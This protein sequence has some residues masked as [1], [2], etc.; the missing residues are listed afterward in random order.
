[1]ATIN[2]YGQLS[3][4]E[5]AKRSANGTLLA[6][7]ENLAL[8]NPILQDAPWVEANGVTNHIG[9]RRVALPTGTW[10]KINEGIN[11]TA[12]QTNQVTEGIGLLEDYSDVDKY[13]VD[14]SGN[15]RRFRTEEDVAHVEGLSQQFAGGLFYGSLSNDPA[16]F[17]GLSVRYNLTSLSNVIG[18]SGTGSDTCSIWIVQWGAR[19]VHLLYPKGSKTYGIE[20][21]DLGEQTKV[22]TTG[23]QFQIY[24]T[25]FKLNAGM[26]IHDDRC[27]Q[28]I[29]NIEASGS[30]NIFDEDDLITALNNLPSNG[31]G[32][33]IYVSKA[34]KNQMDINAKDK[35]NVAYTSS[36]VYGKPTTHFWGVP[37]KKCDSLLATETAIS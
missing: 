36:E 3:L 28:R 5:L 9:T 8:D 18:A 11:P 26:Y 22:L 31:A 23:K 4:V 29:A 12:S 15:P 2:T 30:S 21:R 14:I 33:V 25:H 27:I 1:M 20:M 24:R 35:A 10:R 17:N 19:K 7:A 16:S 6:I 32:A 13:L 37:V 34:V